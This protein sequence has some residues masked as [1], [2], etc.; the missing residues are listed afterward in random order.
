MNGSEKISIASASQKGKINE[1]INVEHNGEPID[2]AVNARFILD[3]L[4]SV[5]ETVEMELNGTYS[6]VLI[7]DEGY[8]HIVLPVR[9]S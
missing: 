8:I 4:D 7:R 2:I 6:P 3:A 1:H 5:G 9:V